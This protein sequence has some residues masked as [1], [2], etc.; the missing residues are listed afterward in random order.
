[1]ESIYD[2]GSKIVGLT[3]V[4]KS[5][6]IAFNHGLYSSLEKAFEGTQTLTAT[7]KSTG[8]KALSYGLA[9]LACINTI[10]SAF[11][12]DPAARASARGYVLK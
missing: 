6:G 9:A 11:T 4:T 12:D 7:L 8:G 10:N 5:A 2:N 3:P 1:M